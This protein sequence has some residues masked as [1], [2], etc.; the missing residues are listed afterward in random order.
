MTEP[1]MIAPHPGAYISERQSQRI[2]CLITAAHIASGR[3]V[4]WT[5]V[6]ATAR[7]LYDGG[8]LP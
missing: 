1:P 5:V 8:D 6:V 7:W 4:P 2:A 3:S